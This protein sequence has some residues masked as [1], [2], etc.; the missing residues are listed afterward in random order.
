MVNKQNIANI[1][2]NISILD[3]VLDTLL[4]A[5]DLKRQKRFCCNL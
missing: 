4:G 1:F 5:K 2:A 3:H